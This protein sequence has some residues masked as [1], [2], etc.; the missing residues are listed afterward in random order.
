[1]TA[2]ADRLAQRIRVAGPISVAD[3]ME[4]AGASYYGSRDPFGVAGD[5]ITAPEVSQIFGELIGAWCA[6]FWQRN[7]ASDPVLLVELGPGRGTLMADALRATRN[8]PGF[9]QALRLHLVERSPALRAKQADTLGAHA[10]QWHDNVA[11]LPPGP[12]LLIANE[13]L[14]ALPIIQ[15]EQHGLRWYERM[16]G[17]DASGEKLSFCLAPQ[18]TPL[19]G[20][21]SG[22]HPDNEGKIR[23]ISPAAEKLGEAI[24]ARLRRH[25]GAALFI[26]YGYDYRAGDVGLGDTLQALHRHRPVSVF[27]APGECD[28]TAHVDFAAFAQAAVFGGAVAYGPA[29][30]RDFLLRLGL[31]A[32]RAKLVERAPPAQAEGI[33]AACCRLIDAAQMGT[34]FKVLALA[35]R[36]APMPAGFAQGPS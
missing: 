9:A 14:D 29:T 20:W 30:Q 24:G 25:G 33:N 12:M 28:L 23:A 17:L 4:E 7:G 6:D 5:F 36:N 16:V 26:D 19:D 8:V 21:P 2:V 31:E 13:F 3:Y 34:L 35:A 1:M 32:R 10:P 15:F 22:A 27:D 18:P 11:S